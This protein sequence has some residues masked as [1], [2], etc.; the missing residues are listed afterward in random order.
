MTDK[1]KPRPSGLV[2]AI[3]LEL[4]HCHDPDHHGILYLQRSA[5]ERLDDTDH[6]V[7]LHAGDIKAIMG[8]AQALAMRLARVEESLG[9]TEPVVVPGD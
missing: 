6:L 7:S 5:A 4:K 3:D 1:E 9:I 2:K 8:Y